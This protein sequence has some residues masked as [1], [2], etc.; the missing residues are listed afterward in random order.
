[1]TRLTTAIK[2]AQRR[3]NHTGRIVY[4]AMVANHFELLRAYDKRVWIA[5]VPDGWFAVEAA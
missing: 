4:V 1:M 3:A 2:H 5:L